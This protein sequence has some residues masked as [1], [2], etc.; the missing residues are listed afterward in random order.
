MRQSQLHPIPVGDLTAVFWGD[1]ESGDLTFEGLF[2]NNG[3]LVEGLSD[4][5]IERLMNSALEELVASG[6]Q[7]YGQE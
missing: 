7:S 1:L 3:Q 6:E 5:A 2:D 4:R